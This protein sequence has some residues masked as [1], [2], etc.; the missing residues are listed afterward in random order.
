MTNGGWW[1]PGVC[2]SDLAV[3]GLEHL[4]ERGLLKREE[5]DALI[6]VTQTP[7]YLIPGTSCIIQGGWV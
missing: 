3:F 5:I 1:N 4:F 2:V 7:D 6:V